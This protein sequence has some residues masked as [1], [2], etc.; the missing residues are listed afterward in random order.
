[1]ETGDPKKLG[2]YR[3]ATLL[4]GDA[5]AGHEIEP[6]VPAIVAFTDYMTESP[7]CLARS[8]C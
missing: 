7:I 4:P 5:I 6:V 1:M 2:S 3:R 8:R